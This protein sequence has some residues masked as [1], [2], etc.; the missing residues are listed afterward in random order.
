MNQIKI[1]KKSLNEY[2]IVIFDLDGTLLDTLEDLRNS[3]NAALAEF[4]LPLRTLDEVRCF[5]GNGVRKLM[6]RAV[7][8][9]EEHP[10]FEQIFD[11][12][13][14]HYGVHCNDTTE[15]YPDVIHLLNE[16]KARGIRMG[17]VSNK[18]DS[19]VKELANIYFEGYMQSAIGEKEGVARKPAPDTAVHAMMELDV[20][21]EHA[22]YVGD[23]DVDI[24]T[25]QN[26]G[27]ECIS[28]TWGFRD[29]EFLVQHGATNLIQQPLELLRYI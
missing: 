22:L 20:T 2:K 27:M 17:I 19:A 8:Q 25:A 28:V 4:G 10:K 21:P 3:V 6:I 26:A 11:Y 9:G 23:S 18:I 12:F 29:E 14:K 13:K 24:A 5:V 1:R 7:P 16:L 15:P